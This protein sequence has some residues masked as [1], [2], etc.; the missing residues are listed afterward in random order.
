MII[1]D[2]FAELFFTFCIVLNTLILALDH[3]D[4][5]PTLERTLTIGNYVNFYKF[6]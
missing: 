2:A 6:L 4:I 5:N 1:F 3:H